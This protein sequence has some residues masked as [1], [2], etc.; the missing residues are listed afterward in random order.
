MLI[1]TGGLVLLV[2]AG[3]LLFDVV[4]TILAGILAIIA[5]VFLSLRI[6]RQFF[7]GYSPRYHSALC[8]T[9]SEPF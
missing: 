5:V 7:F 1:E 2:A 4:G 8:P 3:A 9:R 6:T